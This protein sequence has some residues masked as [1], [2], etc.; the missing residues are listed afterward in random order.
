MAIAFKLTKPFIHTPARQP[1][2]IQ[3]PERIRYFPHRMTEKEKRLKNQKDNIRAKVLIGHTEV[4]QKTQG[5]LASRA[6]IA[7]HTERLAGKGWQDHTTVVM[8]VIPHRPPV[9]VRERTVRWTWRTKFPPMFNIML[10]IC[11]ETNKLFA[12][13]RGVLGCHF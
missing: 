10:D 5:S 2:A 1:E 8:P 3:T 13:L 9:A 7:V 11:A 12:W 6:A 4:R